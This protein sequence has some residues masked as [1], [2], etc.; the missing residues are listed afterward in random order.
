[1]PEAGAVMGL[2]F[3]TDRGIEGYQYAWGGHGPMDGSKPL[4]LLEHVGGNPSWA[5]SLGRRSAS[6]ITI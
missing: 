4:G 1:M 5:W 3:L 2:S 6:R